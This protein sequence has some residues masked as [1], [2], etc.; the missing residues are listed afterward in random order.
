MRVIRRLQ[1]WRD[2]R[3]PERKVRIAGASSAVPEGG[4]YRAPWN[5]T[6]PRNQAQTGDEADGYCN[7]FTDYLSQVNELYRMLEGSALYG[8]EQTKSVLGFRTSFLAG[9]GIHVSADTPELREWIESWLEREK[10]TGRMLTDAVADSEVVGHVLWTVDDLGQVTCHPS[11]IGYE[12]YTPDFYLGSQTA[13]FGWMQPAW[14]PKFMGTRLVAIQRQVTGTTYGPWMEAPRDRYTYIRTGGH[15]NVARFP[16]PTTRM[17]LCIDSFKN[18]DRAIRE[19]RKLNNKTA[20][21]VQAI[22]HS[23]DGDATDVEEERQYYQDNPLRDGDMVITRGEFNIRSSDAKAV[24]TLKT[25][26]ALIVKDLSG[27]TAVP[28]HWLGY[29]DLLANRA[30]ATSLFEAIA[31]GTHVERL[32]WE[33]GM[34]ELISHGRRVLQG[35][36]GNFK[37]SMPLLSFQQFAARN[38]ALMDLFDRGLIGPAD[39]HGQLPF[40]VQESDANADARREDMNTMRVFSRMMGAD[41]RRREGM[42]D[43]G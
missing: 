39:V 9:E 40:P 36:P 38:D 1:D 3:R 41:A 27:T 34:H 5:K 24:E 25:E 12:G 11:F 29:T 21:Q 37:V 22:E 8:N 16:G 15:G 23:D 26:A 10:L 43:A 20:R 30:T 42:T 14:W 13:A 2:N 6:N 4:Q 19:A 28:P 17:A 18:Y 7:T 31:A 35:P 32:A 33:E